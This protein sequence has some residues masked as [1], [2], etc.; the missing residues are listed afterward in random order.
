MKSSS[1]TRHLR[2]R[3]LTTTNTLPTW[4]V[5]AQAAPRSLLSSA[6]MSTL[7]ASLQLKVSTRTQEQW[8]GILVGLH[9]TADA[10]P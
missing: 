2:T 6:A 1:Q 5:R 10:R 9:K 4:S 8:M 7:E 3:W